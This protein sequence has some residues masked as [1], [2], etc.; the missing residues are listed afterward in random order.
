MFFTDLTYFSEEGLRSVRQNKFISVVAIVTIGFA[1]LIFGAFLIVYSNVNHIT[2][3]WVQQ[4][5]IIAYI[6][7][8]TSSG[9]SDD[10]KKILWENPEV[11][12][13]EYV[14]EEEA[15]KRLQSEHEDAV[16]LLGGL[17]DNPLPAAFEIRLSKAAQNREAVDRLVEKIRKIPELQEVQ[18]G[19]EWTRSLLT[20]M[21][22]LRLLGFILGGLLGV[23]IIFIIANTVRL[24][25]YARRD[26]LAVMRLIG[27]TNWFIKGPFL[28][29]GLLQGLIG[30]LFSLF[31]LLGIYFFWI[32]R[33]RQS[34]GM[35]FLQD[36]SISFLSISMI[37][38][39]ILGGMFLGLFG[40]LISLGRFLKI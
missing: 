9:R 7:G 2:S 34:A 16:Y 39:M 13:V 6:K 15:L 31:L 32:P 17:D 8:G 3:S 40:S 28:M 35:F 26:E 20:F 37:F 4:V 14:S 30:S 36:I 21:N 12:K 24:T 22:I 1:L 18:Y 10:L 29:E 25:V 33:L 11:A 23:A 27:A 5:E 19:Q 38:W